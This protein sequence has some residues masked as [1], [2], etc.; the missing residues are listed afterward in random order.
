VLAPTRADLSYFLPDRVSLS[1]AGHT[2]LPESAISALI[3]ELIPLGAVITPNIW[4]TELLLRKGLPADATNDRKITNVTQQMEAAEELSHLGCKG[5]LV[6]GGHLPL[7]IQDVRTGLDAAK[8][9]NGAEV[10]VV[11]PQDEGV[12]VLKLAAGLSDK[13]EA[14]LRFV[15]DVLF[16][17][18]ADGKAGNYTC[19][20]SRVIP[21]TST[22]GTGCTLSA[23]LAVFLGR[24]MNCE[25]PVSTS[26]LS[27]ISAD[28]LPTC[29]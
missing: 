28:H 17:A 21:T 6:K 8:A 11:W 27:S 26:Q 3:S 9:P 16:E 10:E 29:L 24:G 18:S 22:H 20:V 5:V 12:L 13:E 14:D 7:K 19:F 15:V 1:S 25:C 23:A 2:L 4:E